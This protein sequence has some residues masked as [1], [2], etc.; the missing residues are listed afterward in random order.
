V[1]RPW[2]LC[3]LGFRFC[4]FSVCDTMG[5]RTV[6]CFFPFLPGYWRFGTR[7][8]ETLVGGNR[9]AIGVGFATSLSTFLWRSNISHHSTTHHLNESQAFL[10]S[11]IL[12]G[13]Y[14]RDGRNLLFFSLD[15][16]RPAEAKTRLAPFPDCYSAWQRF[17]PEAGLDSTTGW[18]DLFPPKG[19]NRCRTSHLRPYG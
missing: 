17:G 15:G 3:F 8:A 9:G 2:P 4:V 10:I 6:L 12:L 18:R 19:L 5:S 16:L 13:W 7:C 14:T 11:G 1:T